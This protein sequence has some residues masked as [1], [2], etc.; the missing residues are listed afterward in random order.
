MIRLNVSGQMPS[1]SSVIEPERPISNTSRS[2]NDSWNIPNPTQIHEA[3]NASRSSEMSAGPSASSSAGSSRSD[4]SAPC[5]VQTANNRSVSGMRRSTDNATSSEGMS[6][7]RSSDSIEGFTGVNSIALPRTEH[8]TEDSYTG[9]PH[10]FSRNA[11][12]RAI[13]FTLPEAGERLSSTPQLVACLCLLQTFLRPNDYLKPAANYWL[14][15]IQ[16][17]TAEQDRLKALAIQVITA[18]KRDKLKDAK[19]V[20]EVVR[21]AP[22]LSEVSFRDLLGEFHTEI[23][24]SDMTK[25][26]QIEGLAHLLQGVHPEYPGPDDL[27]EILGLIGNRLQA[28]HWQSP[29]HVYQL[30]LAVSQILDAMADTEVTHLNLETLHE[31]L[32]TYLMELK[33]SKDPYLV[34]QAEYAFQALLCVQGIK[35]W[36]LGMPVANRVIHPWLVHVPKGLDFDLFIIGLGAIQK[37]SAGVS[38]FVETKTGYGEVTELAHSGQGLLD[39]LKEGFSYDQ[40]RKWYS[41]LRGADVLIRVGEFVTFKE[42]VYKVPCRLD[43]AFQWGV[44]QRLGEIAVNQTWD[45]DTRRDAITFLGEIYENDKEWGQHASIKQWIL[46]ILMQLSS[47]DD[48]SSAESLLLKL[49]RNGDDKKQALYRACRETGPVAYPLRIALPE[50]A[51]PSLLDRAQDVQDSSDF[52]E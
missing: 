16:L 34:Y 20:A 45:S 11:H 18:F 44:C 38:K 9:L 4:L 28:T 24:Q 19:A 43:L 15:T 21:L 33:G 10:I 27:V 14:Y 50:P 22:V 47:R 26:H 37:G 29:R 3:D 25:F 7:V 6:S 12:Q 13:D 5:I 1:Q 32:L 52:E 35:I 40:K 41:A 51:S 46:N 23:K 31:P 8:T 48:S 30:T 2:S 39:S 42:M 17:D 49:G 36:Q